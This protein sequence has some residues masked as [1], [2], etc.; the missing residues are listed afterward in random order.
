[1]FVFGD[2]VSLTTDVGVTALKGDVGTIVFI[3]EN[4]QFPYFVVLDRQFRPYTENGG[5]WGVTQA[6]ITLVESE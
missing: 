2:R 6:E 4:R 5:A 1:M 3:D